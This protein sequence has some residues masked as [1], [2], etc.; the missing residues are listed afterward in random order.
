MMYSLRVIL[1]A[2]TPQ[3]FLLK[4]RGSIKP[5]AKPLTFLGPRR[6]NVLCTCRGDDGM[7]GQ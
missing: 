1:E 7:R 5:A 3:V 2:K 4:H 6:A